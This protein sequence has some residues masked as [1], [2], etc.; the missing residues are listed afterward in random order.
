MSSDRESGEAGDSHDRRPWTAPR[1]IVS[2]RSKET[3]SGTSPY[4]A[5]G[6]PT[7]LH[8]EFGAGS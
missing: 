7:P 4:Y 5:E 6:V 2:M 8:F 1:V 3:E